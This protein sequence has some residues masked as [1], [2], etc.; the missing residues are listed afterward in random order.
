MFSKTGNSRSEIVN[1]SRKVL[2]NEGGV[3]L[4]RG[5]ILRDTHGYCQHTSLHI[6]PVLKF[7]KID[8][9][10]T[11]FM[12]FFKKSLKYLSDHLSDVLK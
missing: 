2:E 6:Y 8:L 7:S 10:T 5:V 9:K 4:Q 11:F 3:I 1:I 12:F